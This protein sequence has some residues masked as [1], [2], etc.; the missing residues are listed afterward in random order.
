MQL[1]IHSHDNDNDNGDEPAA[2]DAP[3]VSPPGDEPPLAAILEAWNEATLRLQQTH[4]ALQSEVA[5]LTDELAAK[6][7]E[8][9]RQNR[10]ADLGRMASHVAHEVRNSLVPVNL[11]LSLLRRRLSDDP[12]SLSVLAKVEAGFTA[13][14]ATVNDLLNFTAH[15][16]PQW[17]TFLVQDLVEEVLQ[18]VA[19]QLEAQS[20]EVTLD[21]PPHTSATADREMLRRAVLN[22]VL[23]AID[24]MP[25]G[26]DLVITSYDRRGG[27]ELEIADSGPGVPEENL[28]RLVDPFFTTKPTGAGLGLSI[29]SRIAEAHGGRLAVMNCPEGGAAFTIELPPRRA[30]GLAA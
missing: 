13:L 3:R 10:L 5:R 30:L 8:L 6:D 28:P 2:A 24:V 18:S 1:R 22:L 27:L 20:I 15:R 29:V 7:K 19:P 21:V 16:E 11:Y 4:E 14:D 17:R 23:N 26:G 12:G 25:R 9:A